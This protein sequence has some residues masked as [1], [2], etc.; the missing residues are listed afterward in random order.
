MSRCRRNRI[1]FSKP[2]TGNC[3]V[4]KIGLEFRLIKKT[5]KADERQAFMNVDTFTTAEIAKAMRVSAMS[6][7]RWINDKKLKSFRT[8][9]GHRRVERKELIRFLEAHKIPIPKIIG[10]KSKTD[11]IVIDDD[12]RVLE[13]INR[14]FNRKSDNIEISTFEN[15]F[16]AG[17]YFAEI[18]PELVILDILMPGIDGFEMCKKMKTFIPNTKVILITGHPE[19]VKKKKVTEVGA[20]AI[21]LKPFKL[22]EFRLIIMEILN[23]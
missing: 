6:V 15:A 13:L 2:S 4:N 23:S 7:I 11:V 9:G 18:R 3:V 8:P 22:E 14:M 21:F 10:G 17:F 19:K 12:K 1:R 20:D 5:D 16:D